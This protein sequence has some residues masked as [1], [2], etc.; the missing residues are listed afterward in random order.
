[1]KKVALIF[2]ILLAVGW[3]AGIVYFTTRNE[4]EASTELVE[5]RVS[6]PSPSVSDSPA[7]E[8]AS[9]SDSAES[10]VSQPEETIPTPPE[11][12]HLSMARDEQKSLTERRQHYAVV[13]AE[14][15]K[16]KVEQK[17]KIM[18]EA[19]DALEAADKEGEA[20]SFL[21][22]GIKKEINSRARGNPDQSL[23]YSQMLIERYPDK[24]E[25]QVF[26]FHYIGFSYSRKR[27]F[28]AARKN[29]LK[30]YELMPDS[31]MG[32]QAREEFYSLCFGKD[33]LPAIEEYAKKEIAS[34]R[35]KELLIDTYVRLISAYRVS[36]AEHAWK[37]VKCCDFVLANTEKGSF[38][39]KNA[40]SR[41][42]GFLVRQRNHK[43]EMKLHKEREEKL[44]LTSE[45]LQRA[46]EREEAERERERE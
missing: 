23:A 26:A 2:A 16:D 21:K 25:V 33:N 5:K 40:E 45:R 27:D 46:R 19:L 11:P 4:K 13:L 32:R 6:T 20:I 36:D 31:K 43:R 3:I 9:N 44:R 34:P 39:Y 8:V 10:S 38:E 42:R 35:S 22:E 29:Y 14:L 24:K 17:S 15:D 7:D 12:D 1:M 28:D 41:K 30:A 18:T 37:G